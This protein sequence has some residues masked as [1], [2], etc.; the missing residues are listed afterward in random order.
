M[1]RNKLLV[2]VQKMEG[3]A[4]KFKIKTGLSSP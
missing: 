3:E 1:I 4:T 2:L